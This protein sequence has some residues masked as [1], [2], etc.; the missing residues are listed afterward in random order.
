MNNN[1]NNNNHDINNNNNNRRHYNFQGIECF[2][3]FSTIK[4]VKFYDDMFPNYFVLYQ[5]FPMSDGEMKFV[6]RLLKN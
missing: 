3:Y 4:I 2:P 1:N 5:Q 6:K